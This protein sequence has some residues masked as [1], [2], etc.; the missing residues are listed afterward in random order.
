M[1]MKT[2]FLL[3]TAA[4]MFS[5]MAGA[6]ATTCTTDSCTI[7]N[8]T[9]APTTVV[10][11]DTVDTNNADTSFFGSTSLGDNVGGAPLN[12]GGAFTTTGL[13]VTY[14]NTT[15]GNGVVNLVFNTTFATTG[16][17]Q[18]NTQTP[19]TSVYAADIFIESGAGLTG[20]LTSTFNYGI[21]LGYT[22]AKDGGI[23]TVGLYQEKSTTGVSYLTSN[24]IWGSG[25]ANGTALGSHWGDYGGEFAAASSV[26]SGDTSCSSAGV[27]CEASPT[28]LT[29]AN[30]TQDTAISVCD[31]SSCGAGFSTAGGND[32]LTV[33]LSGSTANLEALFSDFDIF[34]GTG[35]CSNAPIW[36]NI[37]DL[38]PPGT[39][40]P[41][42]SSLALL[43]SA[44][45]GFE[46]LRRRKRKGPAAA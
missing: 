7:S 5:W 12:P 28:V 22:S 38:F 39:S 8:P 6:Y 27:T 15:S 20:A 23:S 37:A 31:S 10:Q 21:S 26:S 1:A 17:V 43:A 42:P 32:T 19:A 11:A 3:A 36:G 4:G 9:N 46:I 13:T 34:W 29:A 45:I 40:V 24:N 25:S 35:D 14:A 33:A 16:G 44:A 30:S 41:E 18:Q 2:A